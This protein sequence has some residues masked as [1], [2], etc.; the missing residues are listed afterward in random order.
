METQTEATQP[1]I[2][3][4]DIQRILEER[5]RVLSRPPEAE[6]SAEIVPLAVLAV[7]GERYGVDIRHV[8]EIKPL[9]GLTPVPATPGFWRGLVNLRGSL[10]PVLDLRVYLGVARADSDRVGTVVLLS[11]SGVSIGLLADSVPEIV[12]IPTQSIG[13]RPSEARV[14]S[15]EV[16]MGMTPDLLSVI[17]VEALLTDPMLSVQDEIG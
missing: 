17:D 16:I 13:A 7:G 4:E 8:Q 5:A 3:T 1:T 2:G 9:A 11:G 15:A 6:E 10:Y 12:R 14:G